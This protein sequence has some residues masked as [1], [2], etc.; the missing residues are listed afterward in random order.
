MRSPIAHRLVTVPE[1]VKRRTT[2]EVPG[3]PLWW[4]ARLRGEHRLNR[5]PRAD[6]ITLDRITAVCLVIIERDGLDAVT[7]RRVARELGTGSAS[8]YRHVGS[9]AELLAVVADQLLETAVAPPE[10]PS[11]LDWRTR[12]ERHAYEFRRA[13]HARPA[14]IPLITAGQLLGP[15]SLKARDLALGHLLAAGFPPQVAVRVYLSVANYVVGSAQLDNR[16]TSQELHPPAELR[17]LFQ[18]LD[19]ADYPNTHQLMTE[20]SESRA[21][22]EFQ[23]G[24]DAL[25]DGISALLPSDGRAV[26]RPGSRQ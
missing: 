15:N 11:D 8:L 17:A 1:P 3:S 4:L 14:L 26:S 21:D 5:K 20:L 12:T 9:R 13:L 25:L 22:D 24:L 7:T 10:L 6:G 18:E 19:P 23:F 2:V 16:S